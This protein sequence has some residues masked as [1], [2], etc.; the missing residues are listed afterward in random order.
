VAP[1]TRVQITL[2]FGKEKVF[3]PKKKHFL[4]EKRKGVE[5]P[6]LALTFPFSSEKRFNPKKG[7]RAKPLLLLLWTATSIIERKWI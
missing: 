6:A 2:F 1:Q 7:G 4:D 5:I 3:H